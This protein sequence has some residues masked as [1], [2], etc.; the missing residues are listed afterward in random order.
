MSDQPDALR[1]A[2]ELDCESSWCLSELA[3]AELRRQHGEIQ[4]LKVEGNV[5]LDLYSEL[6]SAVGNA[7]LNETRHQTALRYIKQ[8][9][10]TTDAMLA[11]REVKP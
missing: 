7:Y 3:A 1:L 8:A 10:T 4:T 9:E 11:A 6:L 2:G 5:L